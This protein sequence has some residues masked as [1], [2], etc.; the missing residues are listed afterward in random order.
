M[1][2]SATLAVVGGDV[3]QAYLASLLRPTTHT[4]AH[5]CANGARRRCAAV[6]DPA[7]DFGRRR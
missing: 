3:R 1:N 7:P 2:Q 5:L 6:S 4:G